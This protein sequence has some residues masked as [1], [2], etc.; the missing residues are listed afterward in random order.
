MH[1]LIEEK[2]KTQ[3]AKLQAAYRRD[4]RNFDSYNKKKA[5]IVL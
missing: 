2:Q 3:A 1:R 4:Y 5:V